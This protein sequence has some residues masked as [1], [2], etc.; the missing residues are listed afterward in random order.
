MCVFTMKKI[1]E[2]HSGPLDQK[3]EPLKKEKKEVKKKE[4]DAFDEAVDI[5]A[6]YDSGTPKRSSKSNDWGE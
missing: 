5:L 6:G 4:K 3:D 2:Q 1:I